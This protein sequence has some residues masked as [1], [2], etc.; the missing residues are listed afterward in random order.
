RRET[1]IGETALG[2]SHRR[3]LAHLLVRQCEVEDVDIFRQPLDPRRPRYCR[4]ILLHEPAQ[5]NLS[6]ALA[7]VLS[8]PRQYPVVLDT[9]PGDRA[10]GDK[11]HALTGA[12]VQNLGLVQIRMI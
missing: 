3:Y 6:G 7:V 12:G 8:D 1:E 4:N 2:A 10:I 9:A 11:R 5:A